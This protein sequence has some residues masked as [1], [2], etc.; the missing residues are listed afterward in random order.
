[1]VTWMSFVDHPQ[2][3]KNTDHR[4]INADML[5]RDGL[6]LSRKGTATVARNFETIIS[7]ALSVPLPSLQTEVHQATEPELVV[8][9]LTYSQVVQFCQPTMPVEDTKTEA[10]IC[11]RVSAIATKLGL[12]SVPKKQSDVPTNTTHGTNKI[13]RKPTSTL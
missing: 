10:D 1:M 6:H 2:F 11:L 9:P 5:S 4:T 13:R 8:G 12:A 3:F 7:T